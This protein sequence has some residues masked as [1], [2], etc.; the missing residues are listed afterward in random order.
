MAFLCLNIL[1][2][3]Y[4]PVLYSK[5]IPE[6]CRQVRGGPPVVCL[7]TCSPYK[8]LLQLVVKKAETYRKEI[9]RQGNVIFFLFFFLLL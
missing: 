9:S 3:Y 6:L 1:I 8:F 7:P 4:R 5:V 2:P